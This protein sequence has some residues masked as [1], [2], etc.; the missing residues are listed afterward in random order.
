MVLPF[1]EPVRR[2]PATSAIPDAFTA[3]Q[4]QLAK[5]RFMLSV[6]YCIVLAEDVIKVV[7]ERGTQER[8]ARP[9]L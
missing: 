1:Q 8:L 6:A 7:E 4:S 3:T 9:S 2:R 5:L